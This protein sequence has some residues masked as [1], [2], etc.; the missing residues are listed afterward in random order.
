VSRGALACSETKGDG[1]DDHLNIAS[2]GPSQ[3]YEY[4][5]KADLSRPNY[6]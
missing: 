1:C 6:G 5:G 3:K 4:A 2:A